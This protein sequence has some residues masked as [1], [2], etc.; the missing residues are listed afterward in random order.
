MR[1]AL[2]I[3]AAFLVATL[4]RAEEKK[5]ARKPASDKKEAHAEDH[6]EAHAEDHK[7]AHGEGSAEAHAEA[8][9]EASAEASCEAH[10]DGG[11]GKGGALDVEKFKRDFQK[12]VD[13]MKQKMKD[14]MEKAKADCRKKMDEAM[15]KAREGKATEKRVVQKVEKKDSREEKCPPPEEEGEGVEELH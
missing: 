6:K 13:E 14:D 4:V 3:A 7:E 11:D 10:A 2:A 5:V 9:A 15:K 8:H 12:R 1:L